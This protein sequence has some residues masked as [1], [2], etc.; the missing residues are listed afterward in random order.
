MQSADALSM[1]SRPMRFGRTA[2][3]SH[4]RTARRSIGLRVSP[5]ET[6]RLVAG[7]DDGLQGRTLLM[8][9]ALGVASIACLVAASSL[10]V[11]LHALPTG[12]KPMRDAVSDY[13]TT[14]F[15]AY[16][17]AMVVLLGLSAAF[18]A[19]S[20]A[21]S[22][23]A[24]GLLW[25]WLYAGSRVAIARFMTDRDPPPFTTEGRV[26]WLLAAVAYTSIALAA[27]N[28]DWSG[29]PDLLRVLGYGVAVTA[30][31]TFVTRVVGPLR[32]TFG[33]VERLLY[34]TS[35]AWLLVAAVDLV[36]S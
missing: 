31:G 9:T 1:Q 28:I 10:L 8:T 29:A 34:V 7:Y 5:E 20:L 30:I 19:I 13:G 33:L 23:D 16:Y 36:I 21:R 26:H 25:L 35:V 4:R 27:S 18:L 17:R 2:G 15:H 12:L 6:V 3:L 14:R 11:R 22:T 24:T 32:P